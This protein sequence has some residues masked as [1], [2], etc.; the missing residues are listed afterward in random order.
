MT[1][2]ALLFALGCGSSAPPPA[3]PLPSNTAA[4]PPAT[5]LAGDER[6]HQAVDY[7]DELAANVDDAVDCTKRWTNGVVDCVLAALDSAAAKACIPA[8]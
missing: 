2:I 1:R 3:S 5:A 4:A 8:T 7:M 6:C